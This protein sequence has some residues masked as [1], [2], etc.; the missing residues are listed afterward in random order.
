MSTDNLI[1]DS[2]R[3]L[4]EH[5]RTCIHEAAHAAVA[6]RFGFFA[7]WV[8]YPNPTTEPYR[9]KLWAGSTTTY[10]DRWPKKLERAF[11]LAGVIAT[12]LDEDPF[13]TD[14]QILEALEDGV[15]PLSDED[16][17]GARG[18]TLKDVRYSLFAVC[19]L[20]PQILRDAEANALSEEMR[21]VPPEGFN[22][23]TFMAR[24]QLGELRS[25]TVDA[26]EQ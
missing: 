5:R 6:R 8:V 3:E 12:A 16:A 19:R 18:Y 23:S 21:W 10:G 24:T 9:Q 17:I 20:M 11:A 1:R 7:E 15:I 25:V 2:E 14:W 13:I 22:A 26:S 4:I